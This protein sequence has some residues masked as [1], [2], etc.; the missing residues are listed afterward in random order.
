MDFR[1]SAAGSRNPR[2]TPIHHG[3]ASGLRLLTAGTRQA[4]AA[5]RRMI[6]SAVSAPMATMPETWKSVRFEPRGA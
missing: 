2:G 4:R 1:V 5:L 6:A 3:A